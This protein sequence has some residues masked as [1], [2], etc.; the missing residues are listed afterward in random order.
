[1]AFCLCKYIY[2]FADD[3]RVFIYILV[4]LIAH[5]QHSPTPLANMSALQIHRSSVVDAMMI[6]MTIFSH[7][8]YEARHRDDTTLKTY[9]TTLQDLCFAIRHS[10][11]NTIFISLD[12]KSNSMHDLL[13]HS[14]NGRRSCVLTVCYQQDEYAIMMTLYVRKDTLTLQSIQIQHRREKQGVS[15]QIG[16]IS[17]PTLISMTCTH[18]LS[19]RCSG[20][21]KDYHY[22]LKEVLREAFHTNLDVVA[23]SVVHHQDVGTPPRITDS[24]MLPMCT[25]ESDD[26]DS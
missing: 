24:D 9:M 26:S 12:A 19:T 5:F 7:I 14:F 17:G 11:N 18:R 2:E 16:G 3:S 6:P 21:L 15:L 1:M 8:E 4:F 23:A 10:S 13:T 22:L 25:S 20:N